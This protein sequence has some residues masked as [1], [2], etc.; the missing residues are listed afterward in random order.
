MVFRV[1]ATGS[2][3][4]YA[5][6]KEREDGDPFWWESGYTRIHVS[7]E[8]AYLESLLVL[9]NPYTTIGQTLSVEATVKGLRKSSGLRLDFWVDPPQESLKSRLRWK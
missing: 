8:K 9:S 3:D 6:L 4:V 7:G 1:N 2:A 5:T